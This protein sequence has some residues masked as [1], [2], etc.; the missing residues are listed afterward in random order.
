MPQSPVN[1]GRAHMGESLGVDMEAFELM[2][3]SLH[4]AF[5]DNLFTSVPIYYNWDTDTLASVWSW[6]PKGVQF[7]R[8]RCYFGS[9]A[10]ELLEP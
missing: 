8:P 9:L 7:E 10:L 5:E 6:A 1:C 2:L 3:K 4:K